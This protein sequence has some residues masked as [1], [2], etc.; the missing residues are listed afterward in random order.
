M[1]EVLEDYA[2]K[3]REHKK[4]VL[5]KIGIIGC[6]TMGQ[7]IAQIVSKVGIDVYFV[8]ISEER[9]HEIFLELN[10]ALDDVIDKWG[11]TQSEKR[12]IL[13]RIHGSTEYLDIANCDLVIESINSRKPGTHK[14]LRKEIFRKVE[15]VVS[16]DTVLVSN[17]STLV[18]SELAMVLEHPERAVGMHFLSP[19]TTAKIVEIVKGFHTS[20]RA[21]EFVVK[22]A[23]MI[24]KKV[25]SLM[26]T[27]G[28][29]STRLIVTLINEACE[30]LM[31][32]VASTT[33]VDTTL[34]MG[35][36]MQFGPLELADRIG[37]DKVVRWMDNL[38]Q[39]FGDRKFKPNPIIKRLVRYGHIGKKSGAGFY[40]YE[41]E[42]I[43]GESIHCPEFR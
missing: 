5:K 43:V 16:E 26:E 37:L 4:G 38:F 3:Q 36:G 35:F 20:E 22:F 1:Q 33:C 27:P 12:A 2:L 11:L 25:I 24:D 7:E 31:E 10:Q 17:T 19:A 41:K 30:T 28:N 23:R 14:E 39:E 21:Y 42:K 15:A 34:R 32:G 8:D 13:S 18:I 40:Q 6:G 9:I 29:I